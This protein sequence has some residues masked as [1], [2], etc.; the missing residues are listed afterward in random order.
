MLGLRT[1][2]TAFAWESTEIRLVAFMM[3]EFGHLNEA[4]AAW[5]VGYLGPNA[6][7]APVGPIGE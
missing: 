5:M 2:V 3:F 4:E 6:P 1:L 7:M